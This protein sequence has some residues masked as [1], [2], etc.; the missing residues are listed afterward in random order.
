MGINLL[1]IFSKKEKSED[2]TWALT[3]KT[4][5]RPRLEIGI[6]QIL[7]GDTLEKALFG[8]TTTIWECNHC[9]KVKREVFLGSDEPVLDELLDRVAQFGNQ[10]I[11]RGSDTFTI[12]K[13][14]P[15]K[16]STIIPLRHVA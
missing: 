13:W 6:L 16:P 10:S 15:P 11:E 3:G 2:H 12:S 14:S 8:I 4:Y 9:G 5:A 7:S 1:K